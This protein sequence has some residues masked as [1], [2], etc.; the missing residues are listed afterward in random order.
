[1]FRSTWGII[2]EAGGIH[3]LGAPLLSSLKSQGYEGVEIPVKVVLGYGVKSWADTL[4]ETGMKAIYMAFSDGP[5]A[6]GHPSFGGPFAGHPTPGDSPKEHFDVLKAQIEVAY[7]LG[8]V[9]V[10]CHSGRDWFTPSQ[11]HELYTRVAELEAST[12]AATIHETHRARYLHSPWVSR[13]F[14]ASFPSLRMCADLS[15]F[16]CVTEAVVDPHLDAA[17]AAITPAVSHIH[18]RVGFEEGPQVS[19]VYLLVCWAAYHHVG[20]V[21]NR[22]TRRA[23][24]YVLSIP[25]TCMYKV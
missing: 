1:M 3:D 8:P 16:T 15:H 19:R 10:N 20:D 7:S 14:Y 13:D 25:F 6:P 17:I 22:A 18:A 24:Y 12:G 23:A 21:A 2:Q 9:K 5:M 11:A 4:A